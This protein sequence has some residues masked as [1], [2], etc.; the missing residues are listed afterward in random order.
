M[1]TRR[2]FTLVE[3]LAVVAII[4]ILVTLVAVAVKGAMDAAKRA[5]IAV[6]MSQTAMALD[7]HK[8]EFGEHPPDMFDDEAL[9]S[10]VRKRWPRFNVQDPETVR[11]AITS[12]YTHAYGRA[13]VIFSPVGSLALWLGGFP[14]P[15]G[16]LSGFYADPENP[17]T[18]TGTFDQK[19]FLDLEIGENKSVQLFPLDSN[20]TVF[21]PVIA[22]VIRDV[23]VP[24]VYFRGRSSGGNNAYRYGPVDE[25]G[26][27]P[28]VKYFDFS[29]WGLGLCVP[30]A[31]DG[32][33]ESGIVAKWHNPSTYQL[34]HPGLD[35]V[36][37]E[38]PEDPM[39]PH[40][41]T[42][43]GE[44]IGL[45]DLDNLT[46]FSDYKELKSILP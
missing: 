11:G 42:K 4:G 8:A 24:I 45:Y 28:F 39:R 23:P 20:A 2:A 13:D 9:L 16:K 25:N 30:Y 18:P 40:R 34:I 44:N 37:G 43:T 33:T 26:I 38:P 15:D 17:F 29:D 10:Y 6:Q 19:T 14:D 12:A 22:S 27:R 41:V 7:R 46:N 32:D 31:D 5:R 1:N 36:F 3:I 21:V 35:G